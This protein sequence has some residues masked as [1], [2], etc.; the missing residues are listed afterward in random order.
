[1]RNGDTTAL[2]KRLGVPVNSAP[3]PDVVLVDTSQLLYHDVWA[4]ARIAGDIASSFGVRLNRYPTAAQTLVRVDPYYEDERTAKDHERMRRAEVGSKAIH[5]KPNTQL[6][7]RKA[8]M[9]NYKNKSLLASILCVYPL[10]NNMQLVNTL[11][12]LATLQEADT[13][14]NTYNYAGCRS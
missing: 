7:Y 10:Q 6:P 5:L 12:C 2:V 8:I 9:E 11:D 4:V 14:L 1:M 3:A 13:R